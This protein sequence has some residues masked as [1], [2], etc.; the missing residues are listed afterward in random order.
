MSGMGALFAGTIDGSLYNSH[1]AKSIRVTEVTIASSA[2]RRVFRVDYVVVP[3]AMTKIH[4]DSGLYLDFRDKDKTW[5][6]L[7][8]TGASWH[9]IFEQPPTR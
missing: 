2:G 4:F 6:T 8:V 5:W 1:S 9:N 3:Q 7:S